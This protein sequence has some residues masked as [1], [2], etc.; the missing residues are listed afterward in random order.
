M[1]ISAM[2]NVAYTQSLVNQY[3]SAG[4]DVLNSKLAEAEKVTISDEARVMNDAISTAV[5]HGEMPKPLKPGEL[6]PLPEWSFNYAQASRRAED[7]L[8]AAMQQLGIPSNSKVSINLNN[9]GAISV[10]GGGN[11]NA[12]LEAIVNNNMDLRNSIVAAQ[13][14]AYMGRIGDAVSQ[15]Q[16]AMNANPSKADYYNNWLMGTVKSIMGMGFTFDFTDGKLTGLFL[17]GDQK[18]GLMENL[19]K[20]AV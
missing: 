12:E 11:K 14:S 19:P 5:N 8:K 18:I 6:P 16:N 20:L 15:A 2:P 1:Q 4:Q 7:G 3:R 13:N 9:D 17:S 10:T